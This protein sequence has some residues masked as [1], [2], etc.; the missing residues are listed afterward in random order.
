MPP[1]DPFDGPPRPLTVPITSYEVEAAAKGLKNGRATGPDG[2]PSELVK[3]ANQE[4]F[5]RYA[6]CLNRAPSC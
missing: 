6:A 3:Y 2:I 4:V 1:L 5:S